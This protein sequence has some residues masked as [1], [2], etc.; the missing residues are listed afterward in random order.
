MAKYR[1]KPVVVE[2]EQFQPG[3]PIEG[4]KEVPWTDHGARTSGVEGH[5]R[6]ESTLFVLVPG[7]WAIT[8]G[9][10]RYII[11]NDRFDATYEPVSTP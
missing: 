10:H 2:A 5:L 7:D 4:V 3:T 6:V 9:D 8:E 1:R 11:S